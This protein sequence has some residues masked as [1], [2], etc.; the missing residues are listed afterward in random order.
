MIECLPIDDSQ[1]HDTGGMCT[2]CPKIIFKN[3]EMIVIHMDFDGQQI[4]KE[5]NEILN[6]QQKQK[7]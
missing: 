6:K 3:G 4:V 7:Q 2:F 1:K 5:T